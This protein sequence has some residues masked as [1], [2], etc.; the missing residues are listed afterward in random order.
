MKKLKLTIEEFYNIQKLLFMEGLKYI[1]NNS[2][3]IVNNKIKK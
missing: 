1:I 3:V 2:K